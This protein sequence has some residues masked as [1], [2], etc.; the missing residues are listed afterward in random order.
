MSVLVRYAVA[1]GSDDIFNAALFRFIETE[2]VGV[3]PLVSIE[4]T[5]DGPWS[6]KVL[7]FDTEA[8]ASN[9]Q[10]FISRTDLWSGL[11]DHGA[12]QAH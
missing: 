9:F 12:G 10:A 8:H 2:S 3:Q 11:S 4:S 6:R 5:P 7:E 1:S